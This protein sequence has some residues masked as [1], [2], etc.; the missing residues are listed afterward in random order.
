[1]NLVYAWSI[2]RV[3]PESL[4]EWLTELDDLL[5]WQETTSEAAAEIESNSFFS[6]QAKGSR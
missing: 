5:P 4:D 1:M 3:K 6:M 2:E